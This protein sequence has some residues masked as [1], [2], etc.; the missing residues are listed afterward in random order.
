MRRETERTGAMGRTIERG[1]A[2]LD[3]EARTITRLAPEELIGRHPWLSVAAAVGAGYLAASLTRRREEP[4]D[5]AMTLPGWASGGDLAEGSVFF[6]GTA[7]TIIRYGGF[8]LLTDPNFLHAGDHVHLGYGLT[9]PR[10]TN[11]ALEVDQLPPLDLCLLSHMHGDHWDRVASERLPKELPVVTTGHAAGSLRRQGFRRTCTLDTWQSV[12]VDKGEVRL[13]ITAM[14]GK[15]GPGALNALLPP[16]MGSMLEWSLR[17]EPPC[18][19]MYISGDTLAT[20]ELRD[21]PRRYPDI[22]LGLMHLGGTMLFGVLLTMDA[23]QGVQAVRAIRPR[24]VVPIHYNDYPVFR[25]PV[26]DFLS[27]MAR[28]L[29]EIPVHLLRHGETFSYRVPQHRYAPAPRL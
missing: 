6:V 28:E 19:R 21:I 27:A 2:E 16:V 14:P 5:L 25:S 11:P 4:R 9:S 22:D 8:T 18:F 13:R 23:R 7:T 12:T 17:D 15:H 10:L 1:G 20:D 24:E 3:R 29:P 26:E